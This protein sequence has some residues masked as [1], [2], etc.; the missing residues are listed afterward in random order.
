[1][2]MNFPKG[3]SLVEIAV[4]LVIISVLL[5]IIAGPI[6]GQLD[7]RKFE[8]IK[9]QEELVKETILGFAVINGRLPCPALNTGL[10]SVGR[11]CFCAEGTGASVSGT[12]T[13]TLNM[14]NNFNGRCAAFGTTTTALAAGFLPT[15]SLG[16]AS[17]DTNG[18]LLDAFATSNSQY[19]YAVAR[20]TVNGVPFALTSPD[21]I[22]LAT[23]EKFGGTTPPDLLTICPPATPACS[24][25]AAL[26]KQAPF[27]VF[28]LGRNS[29]TAYAS[30]GS[31]E[32][33]NLDDDTSYKFVSGTP[34]ANFDDVLSWSSI[35]IL[36]A[37]MVQ[38]GKLP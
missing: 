25:T 11:E 28:S 27:I 2:K 36:F 13:L 6:A 31:A 34:E 10:C 17:S 5:T 3:F 19:R 30:L 37:R 24:G 23:M 8:D 16:I 7:Q 29:A 21:G 14:P 20:T 9:K 32:Q 12:C 38:A 18:Y 33:A 35:N 22:K 26:T 4:V 15:M 1:M